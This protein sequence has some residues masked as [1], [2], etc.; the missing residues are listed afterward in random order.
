ME[1]RDI[2]FEQRDGVAV[3]T[4]QRPDQLNAFS[5]RMGVELGDAYG[6]LRRYKRAESA[7]TRAIAANPDYAAAY[8]RR[9]TT[10]WR[11]DKLSAASCA[12]RPLNGE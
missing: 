6:H 8:Q 4:L 5:G 10:R 9:A 11:L 3:V 7:Y 1:Y 2:R 12:A